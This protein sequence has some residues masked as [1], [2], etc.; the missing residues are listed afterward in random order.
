V[1]TDVAI[2]DGRIAQIG[3]LDGG[4]TREIDAT[5]KYVAPGFIDMMDQSGGAL[6]KNGAAENK[7]RMGVTSVIAGEGGTPV[8]A[9]RIEGYFEQLGRQGIAVNFGTYYSAAQARVQ[10]M[11]DGAGAPTPAQIDA[12]QTLV[13]TAMKAGVF[14]ITSALIYPP[15]SFQTTADLIALAKV[16][17]RCEGFYATHMR[18]ESAKLLDAIDEAIAIGEQ[19]G[20]AEA[21]HRS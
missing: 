9:D 4:G 2:K 7:L 8:P 5:G 18:D 3:Q 16:A 19:G 12:M 17:G 11:G 1:R 14:G 15:E 6:L 10:V 20:S 21:P 13:A